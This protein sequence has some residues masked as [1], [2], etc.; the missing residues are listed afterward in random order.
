MRF[1]QK[2]AIAF[3]SFSDICVSANATETEIEKCNENQSFSDEPYRR[4]T[5]LSKLNETPTA[6]SPSSTKVKYIHIHNQKNEDGAGPAL[7][8][9]LLHHDLPR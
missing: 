4:K 2:V 7:I 3:K 9:A 6:T 1:T 5:F 8:L